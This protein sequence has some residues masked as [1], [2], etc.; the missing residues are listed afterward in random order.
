MPLTGHVTGTP[1]PCGA[2][3]HRQNGGDKLHL[4]LFRA[5]EN[6]PPLIDPNLLAGFAKIATPKISIS[7][8]SSGLA[9]A[10]RL[11]AAATAVNGIQASL[12]ALTA[13]M[14]EQIAAPLGSAQ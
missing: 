4:E 2:R 9:D 13:G 1:I 7:V 6:P 14:T 8:A 5:F 11:T 3:E 12:T 10:I